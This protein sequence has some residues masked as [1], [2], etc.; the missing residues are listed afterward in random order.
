VIIEYNISGS[1]FKDIIAGVKWP[2]YQEI[3]TY[4]GTNPQPKKIYGVANT[5]IQVF[6]EM[7]QFKVQRI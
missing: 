5:F 1:Y 4:F 3:L 7:G 6:Q 2:T